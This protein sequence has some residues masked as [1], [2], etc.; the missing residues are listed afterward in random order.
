MLFRS[1]SYLINPYI[2]ENDILF[3]CGGGWFGSLW[4]HNEIAAQNILKHHRDNRVIVFPQTVFYTSDSTGG[5]NLE[6]DKNFFQKMKHLNVFVRENVSY[7]FIVNNNLFANAQISCI[8]DMVLSYSVSE[9]KNSNVQREG[10]LICLRNDIEAV[11]QFADQNYIVDKVLKY[12]EKVK[13][14]STNDPYDPVSLTQRKNVITQLLMDYSK[15][16][17][18]I[19]DRLHCMLFAAITGTCCIAFDNRTQKVK[20]VYHWI[21]EENYIE[22][23]NDINEFD[24]A[25]CKLFGK[26]EVWD[27]Q[28]VRTKFNELKRILE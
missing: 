5:R 21:Q 8:P 2:R 27:E 1:R 28:K 14:I 7:E 13:F 11:L 24:K 22:V 20:G 25:F 19:T 4:R 26:K 6:Y 17:M 3:V 15:A 23:I 9:I 10:V 18:V 12:G 16:K